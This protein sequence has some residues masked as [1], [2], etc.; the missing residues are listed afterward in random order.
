MPKE[1]ELQELFTRSPKTQQ[2]KAKAQESWNSFVRARTEK[3]FHRVVVAP[4][5]VT[6]QDIW[7]IIEALPK[8]LRNSCFQH[9]GATSDQSS[10]KTSAEE[11]DERAMRAIVQA[12]SAAEA[13]DMVLCHQGEDKRSVKAISKSLESSGLVPLLVESNIRQKR[14]WPEVV[15]K[16]VEL[17]NSAAVC[18]GK[19]GWG[20]WEEEETSALLQSLLRQENTQVISI[21]LP[22]CPTTSRLPAFLER[23]TCVDLRQGHSDAAGELIR[24]FSGE[25]LKP[26]FG[27]SM[28]NGDKEPGSR[29]TTT[30]VA[31]VQEFDGIISSV[32]DEFVSIQF[33]IND[34]LETRRFRRA[35]LKAENI[36][37]GVGVRARCELVILAPKAVAT[38]RDREAQDRAE[39]EAWERNFKQKALRGKSFVEDTE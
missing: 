31:L 25:R 11:S 3:A 33:E 1:E 38:D 30:D 13:F 7:L 35:D 8:A 10:G 21:L 15:K 26:I 6:L 4:E 28:K 37:L 18:V 9:T 22:G 32:N 16:R 20:P 23:N 36:Q 2:A 34:D 17:T 5:Q 19:S 29:N 24:G 14:H 39:K 12:K 27:W